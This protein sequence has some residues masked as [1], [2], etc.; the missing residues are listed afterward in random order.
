MVSIVPK[1]TDPYAN[2]ENQTKIVL[3]WIDPTALN[4]ENAYLREKLT[5]IYPDFKIFGSA[6]EGQ[7]FIDQLAGVTRIILIV[8]GEVGKKL[9]PR[10]HDLG[11]IVSIFIFC[12]KQAEHIEWAKNYKKVR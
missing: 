6:E 1:N 2:D 5:E 10:V 7:E 12:L 3:L 9:V 4:E 8:S 11:H